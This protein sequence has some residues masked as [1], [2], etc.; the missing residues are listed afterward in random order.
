MKTIITT[1]LALFMTFGA[2]SAGAQ[3]FQTTAPEPSK[4]RG[5]LVGGIL[6]T[7]IGGGVGALLMFLG[8]AGMECHSSESQC[9]ENQN[10]MFLTGAVIAGASAGVGIPLIVSGAHQRREWRSWKQ[11][12]IQQGEDRHARSSLDLGVKRLS[13]GP[14]AA[15]TFAFN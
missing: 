1:M 12:Q 7:S 5:Q 13:G 15:L 9:D 14:A 3:A 11:Q 8:V 6:L 10:D 2:A 4:G